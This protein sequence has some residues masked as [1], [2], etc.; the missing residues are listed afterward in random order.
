MQ[1]LG[2][3]S[4]SRILEAYKQKDH[5]N[6]KLPNSVNLKMFYPTESDAYQLGKGTAQAHHNLHGIKSSSRL[7][8]LIHVDDK[9]INIPS[10]GGNTLFRIIVDDFT[11]YVWTLIYRTRDQASIK[12]YEWY[13]TEVISRGFTGSRMRLD[14]AGENIG[15]EFKSM[16]I[17]RDSC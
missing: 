11:R 3:A 15:S 10:W 16:N 7:F 9:I 2:F 14:N 5:N 12:M 4:P 17:F 6:L 13:Q 8:E 1:R